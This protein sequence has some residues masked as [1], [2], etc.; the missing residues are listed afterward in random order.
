MGFNPF[1]G[2]DWKHTADKVGDA[3]KHGGHEVGDSLQSVGEE[4]SEAIQ[5]EVPA[6]VLSVLHG[7]Q[8]LVASKVGKILFMVAEKAAPGK[9][10]IGLGFVELEIELKAKIPMLRKW[11]QHPPSNGKDVERLCRSL[12]DDDII[13][14]RPAK[15]PGLPYLGIDPRIPVH[16]KDIPKIV[17]KVEH[18]LRSALS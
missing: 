14:V 18:E 4:I 6:I 12:T 10:T 3:F 8:D 15:V 1:S 9:T 11:I 5:E 17:D 7:L 13:I 2:H 16:V